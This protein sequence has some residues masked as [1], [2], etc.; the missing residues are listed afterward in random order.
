MC[1]MAESQNGEAGKSDNTSAADFAPSPHFATL[2][3]Y[4]IIICRALCNR[5]DLSCGEQPCTDGIDY[6]LGRLAVTYGVDLR[7]LAA[8][9]LG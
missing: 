7:Y 2:I 8:K 5:S 4:S 3:F 6:E 1:K 9:T